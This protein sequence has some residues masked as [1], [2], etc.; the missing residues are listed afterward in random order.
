M[1]G[2]ND[3]SYSVRSIVYR[4]SRASQT[5]AS[6]RIARYACL[7]SGRNF[8]VSGRP[9]AAL[10]PKILILALHPGVNIHLLRTDAPTIQA[11]IHATRATRTIQRKIQRYRIPPIAVWVTRH[12][13]CAT[14]IAP[15]VPPHRAQAMVRH[16]WRSFAAKTQLAHSTRGQHPASSLAQATRAR[17]HQPSERGRRGGGGLSSAKLPS[18]EVLGTRRDG[19]TCRRDVKQQR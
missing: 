1:Y 12:Y 14:T 6:C 19:S 9:R 16:S 15:L 7:A 4:S 2:F 11:D 13:N 5:H 8:L 10:H 17:A 3:T 18:V